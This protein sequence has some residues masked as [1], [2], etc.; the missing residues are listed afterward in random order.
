MRPVPSQ[1]FKALQKRGVNAASTKL[2]NEFVVVDRLLLSVT[3][4]RSLDVPG[5]HDLLVRRRC[6]RRLNRMDSTQM[7]SSR[8]NEPEAIGLL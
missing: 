2:V 1:A 8:R 5:C 6:I 3:R 4:N 7:S